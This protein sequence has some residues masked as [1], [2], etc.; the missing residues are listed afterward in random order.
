MKTADVAQEV[1][2]AIGDAFATAADGQNGFVRAL[3][4]LTKDIISMYLKQSIAAMIAASI[5]DPTTPLPLAKI[6]LAAAGI[7]AI[8]GLFSQIGNSG[9]S[10]SGGGARIGASGNSTSSSRLTT[11]KDQSVRIELDTIEIAGDKML[12]LLRT[13]EQKSGSRRG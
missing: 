11:A 7:A 8:N 9:G 6:G 12:L 2:S 13:A 1:G 3:A 10:G 4:G 5:K